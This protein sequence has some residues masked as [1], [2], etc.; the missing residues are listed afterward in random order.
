MRFAIVV[1]KFNTAITSKL[2]ANCVKTLREAGI[3]PNAI[4][5]VWVPGSYE[6]PWAVNEMA[7]SGR[8]DSV[9]AIGC[10]LKGQTPQNDYIAAAV[11]QTLQDI[12][13]ATRVPC[14]FGV[15]TPLTYRQAVARTKGDMDRGKE[16]AEVALQMAKVKAE[17][18]AEALR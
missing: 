13:I 9:I 6:I 12:A 3:A 5:T 4:D 14:V 8:Y 2:Q 18:S 16:A 15:I 11:S 17:M 7:R 1:A 10:I